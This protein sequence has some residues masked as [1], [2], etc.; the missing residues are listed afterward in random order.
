MKITTGLRIALMLVL[1]PI[2]DREERRKLEKHTRLPK[3]NL[4]W[5]T[6]DPELYKWFCAVAAANREVNGLNI[7]KFGGFSKW[8]PVGKEWNRQMFYDCWDIYSRQDLIE[9][10]QFMMEQVR[11]D[12]DDPE[13][14]PKEAKVWQLQR[15]IQIASSGYL[16]G[17]LTLREALNT[18]Y[19]AGVLLQQVVRSWEELA[20]EYVKAYKQYLDEEGGK[21]RQ[22]AYQ[23]LRDASHSIYKAVPFDL[24]LK[25]T[26]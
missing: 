23:R 24:Q 5:K 22:A 2:F 21:E 14:L 9:T 19:A 18:S 13:K 6:V 12:F 7:R 4:R 10:I 20:S 16:A 11:D 8:N 17:Y 26:W 25:K 3:D 1:A 15:L